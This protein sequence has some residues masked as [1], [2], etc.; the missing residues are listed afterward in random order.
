MTGTLVGRDPSVTGDEASTCRNITGTEYLGADIFR[1][2][3][4]AEP[5]AKPSYT[6]V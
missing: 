2:F 1:E 5:A 3:C 6:F 4:Q